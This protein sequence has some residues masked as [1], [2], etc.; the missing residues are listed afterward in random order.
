MSKIIQADE[1]VSPSNEWVFEIKGTGVGG[2]GRR[3]KGRGK[4]NLQNLVEKNELKNKNQKTK[5][6]KPPCIIID[7][8]PFPPRP[9]KPQ[10]S[11]KAPKFS[12]RFRP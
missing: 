1:G 5:D 12:P 8:A 6:K 3:G 4:H 10:E 9:P 2:E 11:L 7:S